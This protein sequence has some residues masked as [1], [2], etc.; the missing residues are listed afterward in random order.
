MF[1]KNSKTKSSR[2]KPRLESGLS[3]LIH[4]LAENI[5]SSKNI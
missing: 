1:K 2:V 4:I 3:A 5:T